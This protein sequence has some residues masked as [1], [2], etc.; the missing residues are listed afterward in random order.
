MKNKGQIVETVDRKLWLYD[1]R[2]HAWIDVTKPR[3][4]F[5]KQF[6]PLPVE[7]TSSPLQDV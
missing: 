5:G 4:A 7:P 1:S 6:V 3:K 2:A